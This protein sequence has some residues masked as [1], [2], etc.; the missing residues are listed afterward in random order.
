MSFDED[1]LDADPRQHKRRTTVAPSNRHCLERAKLK[2]RGVHWAMG[3]LDGSKSGEELAEL[4]E[5][6]RALLS[7]I[8]IA[9]EGTVHR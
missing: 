9:D 4:A 6:A 5:A 7:I 8:A 2:L 3:R 1:R